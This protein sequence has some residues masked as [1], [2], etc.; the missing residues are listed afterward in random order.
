MACCIHRRSSDT[1]F[2]VFFVVCC[3]HICDVSGETARARSA[4]SIFDRYEESL[5]DEALRYLHAKGINKSRQ[6]EGVR[7]NLRHAKLSLKDRKEGRAVGIERKDKAQ[8]D[9]ENGET[10]RREICV[11]KAAQ[12]M[13]NADDQEV[14]RNAKPKKKT[15]DNSG[16]KKKLKEI[17]KGDILLD[18]DTYYCGTKKKLSARAYKTPKGKKKDSVF[19]P[20]GIEMLEQNTLK[21][22]SIVL[23]QDLERISPEK[24]IDSS[25]I[26]ASHVTESSSWSLQSLNDQFQDI[27]TDAT[28][29]NPLNSV[30]ESGEDYSFVQGS[31]G[32]LDHLNLTNASGAETYERKAKKKKSTIRRDPLKV[33]EG[34][35]SESIGSAIQGDQIVDSFNSTDGDVKT[36][37]ECCIVVDG[38]PNALKRPRHLVGGHTYDPN[39]R[40]K[41]RFLKECGDQLPQKPWQGAMSLTLEFHMPR[42]KI[43]FSS[44]KASLGQLK[45]SAPVY[46]AK[47]PD[48]DNLVKFVLD[49]L[50]E[51]L[52]Q[53]DKQICEIVARKIY[54]NTSGDGRTIVY[55]KF[56]ESS[57]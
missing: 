43:H 50:N 32:K 52:Y 23:E 19:P 8:A 31:P 26:L 55:A 51:K 14:I 45:D 54:Q 39:T 15:C 46:P 40:E 12:R 20:S 25:P 5:S 17:S 49:A 9:V 28:L 24:A 29:P 21:E 35:G 38:K 44:R 4:I 47:V 11:G 27:C 6:K 57:A 56:L 42:P 37:L 36:Q 22:D 16:N 10:E 2:F 18:S 30:T 7:K 34:P 3:V 41:K 33:S 48:L 1:L 53:D 13:L